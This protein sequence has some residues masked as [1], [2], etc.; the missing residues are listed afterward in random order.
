MTTKWVKIDRQEAVTLAKFCQ[1]KDSK[2]CWVRCNYLG[3]HHHCCAWCHEYERCP[4][5]VFCPTFE[6]RVPSKAEESPETEELVE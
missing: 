3:D 6:K 5:G 2:S 1:Y 4:H